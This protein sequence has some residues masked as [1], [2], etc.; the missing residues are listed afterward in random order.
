MYN[1][2]STKTSERLKWLHVTK[3]V[4]KNLVFF[5]FTSVKGQEI[6]FRFLLLDK[7]MS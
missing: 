5:S 7:T 3:Q 4:Q 2:T 1:Q 6:E